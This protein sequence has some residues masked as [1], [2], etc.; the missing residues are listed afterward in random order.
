[1]IRK[2]SEQP[3]SVTVEGRIIY[4][5]LS[6]F[7]LVYYTLVPEANCTLKQKKQ[8]K[9]KKLMTLLCNVFHMFHRLHK[10]IPH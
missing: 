3:V 1:M 7:F 4:L 9:T 8:N 6:F 2:L 5:L 10:M